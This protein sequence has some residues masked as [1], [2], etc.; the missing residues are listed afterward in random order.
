MSPLIIYALVA[1]AFS[2]TIVSGPPCNFYDVYVFVDG[3]PSGALIEWNGEFLSAPDGHAALR[4]CPQSIAICIGDERYN[5]AI[6]SGQTRI[7]EFFTVS[8]RALDYY[9]NGLGNATLY[10]DNASSPSLTLLLKGR[11]FFQYAYGGRLFD[12]GWHEITNSC[13]INIK[14]A[15]SDMNLQVLEGSTK[16]PD[17]TLIAAMVSSMGEYYSAITEGGRARFQKLP[18][19]IYNISANGAWVVVAH[20]SSSLKRLNLNSPEAI[21]VT[22]KNCY[23]LFPAELCIRAL[24]RYGEPVAGY[25][26]EVSRNGL[27]SS[28]DTDSS[29][30][31]WILI[32][33]SF[34]LHDSISVVG[35]HIRKELQIDQNPVPAFLILS[36]IAIVAFAIAKRIGAKPLIRPSKSEYT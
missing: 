13:T 18:F 36:G 14:L 34:S 15:I 5:V 30:S 21:V 24:D 2:P 17:G 27:S 11:H 8:C 20:N 28:V 22:I 12:L 3:Q 9:G 10:V 16:V 23:L 1:L 33:P 32:P 31:A 4:G 6:G 26:I 25:T 35:G 29:G 19:G 7:V